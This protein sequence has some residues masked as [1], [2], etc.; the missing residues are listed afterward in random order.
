MEIL[1]CSFMVGD[2]FV[3]FGLDICALCKQILH[4]DSDGCTAKLLKSPTAAVAF[5]GHLLH[6]AKEYI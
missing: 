1:H 5:K 3:R 4:S 6:N 2:F